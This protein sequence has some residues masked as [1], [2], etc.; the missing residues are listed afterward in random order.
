MVAGAE[1]G[2]R[3]D[4]PEGAAGAAAAEAPVGGRGGRRLVG[5]EEDGRV[6]QRLLRGGDRDHGFEQGFRGFLCVLLVVCY[7]ASTRAR[8]GERDVRESGGGFRACA[9]ER[10][11]RSAGVL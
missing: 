11:R 2:G 3:P 6:G 8:R 4:V 9:E 1:R 7:P 5:G 10:L